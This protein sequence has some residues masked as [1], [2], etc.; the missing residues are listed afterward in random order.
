[1]RFRAECSH[2]FGEAHVV[3]QPG[4]G[5]LREVGQPQHWL[6]Y[7]Q[8]RLHTEVQFHMETNSAHLNSLLKINAKK[9]KPDV[10]LRTAGK[11]SLRG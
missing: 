9:K 10:D 7:G 1:M 8:Y 4:P 2:D 11:N 6:C 3:R 5:H